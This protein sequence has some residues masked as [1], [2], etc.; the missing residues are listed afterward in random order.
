M[1]IKL[2]KCVSPNSNLVA[3]RDHVCTAIEDEDNY[4]I[5][6]GLDQCGTNLHQA[7]NGDLVF[8]NQLYASGA[9]NNIIALTGE[10][11][12]GVQCSYQTVYNNIEGEHTVH[13]TEFKGGEEGIGELS[14]SLHTYDT[15]NHVAPMGSKGTWLVGETIYFSVDMDVSIAGVEFAIS[16]CVVRDESLDMEYPIINL[17]CKDPYTN[18]AGDSDLIDNK[19]VRVSFKAFQFVS[20][21]SEIS[22]LKIVCS[23]VACATDKDD[24]YCKKSPDKICD[25]RRRRATNNYKQIKLS[26][27]DFHVVKIN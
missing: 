4:I 22:T 3:F 2:D 14:F 19:S 1:T 18:V 27:T 7:E 25:G 11:R 17:G 20:S 15:A 12:I 16:E 6:T 23:A 5:T 10:T 26:S 13:S 21:K 24:T 8:S 9:H